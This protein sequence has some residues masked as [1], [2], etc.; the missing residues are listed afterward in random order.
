MKTWAGHSKVPQVNNLSKL[1][2]G[3]PSRLKWRCRVPSLVLSQSVPIYAFWLKKSI[4]APLSIRDFVHSPAPGWKAR[5]RAS[6]ASAYSENWRILTIARERSKAD[7]KAYSGEASREGER[8]SEQTQGRRT[9]QQ[10]GKQTWQLTLEQMIHKKL[11]KASSKAGKATDSS[12]EVR[13]FDQVRK[14]G[15]EIGNANCSRSETR[16]CEGRAT[17]RSGLA[18]G[19]DV[20]AGPCHFETWKERKALFIYNRA[21]K[22]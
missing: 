4:L 21:S 1:P 22:Y 8:T 3:M 19:K 15:Y 5:F 2:A 13:S 20:R 7:S 6:K 11:D 18:L 12:T 16:E 10:T 9:R 14:R 17:G